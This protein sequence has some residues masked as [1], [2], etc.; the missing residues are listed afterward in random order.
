MSSCV[1]LFFSSVFSYSFLASMR[2]VY[3]AQD[4]SARCDVSDAAVCEISRISSYTSSLHS[5]DAFPMR[6]TREPSI[7]WV[8]LVMLCSCSD[9]ALEGRGGLPDMGDTTRR[10]VTSW[11]ASGCEKGGGKRLT[12]HNANEPSAWPVITAV[13]PSHQSHVATCATAV[14][15]LYTVIVT[16]FASEGEGSAAQPQGSPQLSKTA[17]RRCVAIKTDPS[18]ASMDAATTKRSVSGIPQR[19]RSRRCSFAVSIR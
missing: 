2:N 7:G 12:H 3:P 13:R 15:S 19:A 14:M 4:D 16:L 8:I 18:R 17:I 9:S 6:N 1:C 10:N 11:V 5:P